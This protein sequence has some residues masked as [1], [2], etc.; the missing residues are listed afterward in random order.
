[1]ESQQ[2]CAQSLPPS[3]IC[4]VPAQNQ[5]TTITMQPTSDLI[6]TTRFLI[7]TTA[8]GDAPSFS[9]VLASHPSNVAC[10]HP[11][12]E[13]CCITLLRWYQFKSTPNQNTSY[14]HAPAPHS[15]DLRMDVH[16]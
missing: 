16:H 7:N 9:A 11:S 5:S 4:A 8:A 10:E 14:P 6:R 2:R 13:G 3:S 1:M 12:R 15:P